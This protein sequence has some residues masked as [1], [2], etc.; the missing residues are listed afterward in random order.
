[1]Q[2]LDT[3]RFRGAAMVLILLGFATWVVTAGWCVAAWG[4]F[5]QAFAATRAQAW[6]ATSLVVAFVA[7][8]AWL[9][10]LLG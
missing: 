7:A 10:N 9:A 2:G 5:R 6:L 4:A 3:S 1:M 8:L